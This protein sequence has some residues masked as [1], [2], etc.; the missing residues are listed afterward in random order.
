[1]KTYLPP[2]ESENARFILRLHRDD[3][4]LIKTA[5]AAAEES[6]SEY[7]RKAVEDRL[8]SDGYEED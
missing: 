2:V 7:I 8:R 4:T 5:A 1:M 6:M 3:R